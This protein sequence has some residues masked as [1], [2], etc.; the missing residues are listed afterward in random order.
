MRVKQIEKLMDIAKTAAAVLLSFLATIVL[1]CLVSSTPLE[2]VKD[3]FLGPFQTTRRIGNIIE[4]AIP[5]CFTGCGIC[6]MYSTGHINMGSSGYF[7]MGGLAA[8]VL[9]YKLMLPTGLHPLVC[10]LFGGLIAA[11]IASI[12]AILC[13]KWD[14]NEVVS[15]LMFNYI[16][17]YLGTYILRNFMLDPTAGFNA[18]MA[19]QETAKLSRIIPG[20]RI[21]TGLIIVTAVVI[22]SWLFLR[23][24]KWGYQIRMMG[25]NGKFAIYSGM[26]VTSTLLFSQMLGGFIAGIGGATEVLGMYTRFE[27]AAAPSTGFDG[28]MVAAI[29]HRNP[30]LVPVAALFLAYVRVGADVISRTSDVPSEIVSIIQALIIMLVGA[31]MF[32]SKIRH[33][34]IVKAS[35]RELERGANK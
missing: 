24:T 22:F 17:V 26:G 8:S 25:F 16:W 1:I 35:V 28:I 29:A 27:W 7:Y 32:L 20:T 4:M 30:A 11:L 12:P 33:K 10:I 6:I 18:S 19:Y 34:Q 3:F 15:S 21:H 31:Q 14:I 9:A 23:K 2:T 5:I 13:I